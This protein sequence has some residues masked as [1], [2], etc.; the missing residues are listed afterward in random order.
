MVIIDLTLPAS[1]TA[2][3]CWEVPDAILVRTQAASNCK[4]EQS[5]RFK[6]STSIGI[7]PVGILNCKVVIN[8]EVV[9]SHISQ[10]CYTKRKKTSMCDQK[11]TWV[12][13]N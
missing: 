8:Y 6:H 2:W 1:T 5:S 7:I 12:T 4:S 13:I 9:L 11:L 10:G 3:V